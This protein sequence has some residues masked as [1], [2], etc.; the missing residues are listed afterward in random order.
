MPNCW[1]TVCKLLLKLLSFDLS[2]TTV[3]NEQVAVA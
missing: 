1:A 3:F 2:Y